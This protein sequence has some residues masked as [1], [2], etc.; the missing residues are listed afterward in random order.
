M[1]EITEKTLLQDS[2]KELEFYRVLQHIARHCISE[3][4]KE[5]I[6]DTLSRV[7]TF[8]GCAQNIP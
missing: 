2:L 7:K 3:P 1:H 4:G 6:L 8:N 5:I